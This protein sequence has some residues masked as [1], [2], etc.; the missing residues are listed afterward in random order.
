MKHAFAL[1]FAAAYFG[2]QTVHAAT[3]VVTSL[4]DNGSGSL[5]A[6][7]ALANGNAGADTIRFQP[8]LAGTIV[9]SSGEI[10][11]SDSLAIEGPGATLLTLS[12]AGSQRIFT[13]DRAAGDRTTTVLSGFAFDGGAAN[14]GGA[15]FSDDE[16]LVVRDAIF[17]NNHSVAGG[18]AIRFADGDLTLEDVDFIGNASATGGAQGGAISMAKGHLVMKRCLVQGN[19]AKYGGGL[20]LSTPSPHVVI[21]DSLFLDNTSAYTGGAINAGTAMPSFRVARSSFVGNSSGEPMGAAISFGGA[22]GAGSSPGVIENSTF[23]GNFTAHSN[24]R[25]ILAVHSGVFHLRNSTLAHNRTASQGFA[26]PGYGGAV[27]VG[28]A[29]LHVDSTLFAHNTHGGDAAFR[30]DFSPVSY[31]GRT[32]HV[33][34]SLLH[35]TPAAGL[36]NGIDSNNQYD[37]DAQLLPLA[38]ADSGLA[39]VYPLA[40]HSPAIDAGSNPAGLA[41]DQRGPGFP[42]TLDSV[43]CRNP[44]LARTDIGA[45]EF[46]TD[47]IFCHGFD[48]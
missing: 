32:L 15:I 26:A 12:G 44:S 33:S 36:I 30:V 31:P 17:R 37:T 1:C 21:E 4:A 7:V 3:F 9:L 18:G 13:L 8:G 28:D 25:G 45:W 29:V 48:A 38:A 47:T 6:A 2:V 16:N 40:L 24:G 46:R 14:A 35:T 42:R 20:Y 5:R 19:S 41:T 39:L 27:W 43:A 22:T 10:L 23:S 11:V 34:R